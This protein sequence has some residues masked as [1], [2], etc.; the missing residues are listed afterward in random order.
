[1]AIFLTEV[2]RSGIHAFRSDPVCS[3]LYWGL[4]NRVRKYAASPS[5][6][7]A[8]TDTEWPHHVLEYLTDAAFVCAVAP[9]ERLKTRLRHAA[10]DVAE[11]PLDDWIGPFFRD[12]TATP[13]RGH[14]ETAH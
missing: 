9:E 4:L 6:E 2:E 14:L 8:G 1:M 5:L 11:L 10:L 3:N 13:P 12:H 7:C